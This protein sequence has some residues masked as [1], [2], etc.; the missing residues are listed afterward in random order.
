MT[1]PSPS[2]DRDTFLREAI[3]LARAG[4]RDGPGGPFGAVIVHEARIVGRG[5]NRVVG[6]MDPTAHAEVVAI[7]DACATLNTHV[8][9]GCDVYAT[10]EPCPM[11]LGA[12]YWARVDRVYYACDRDDARDAGFDDERISLE[13]ERPI[14]DRQLG[15]TQALRDEAITLFAEWGA[16]PH[17]MPY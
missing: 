1:P 3:E 4:M 8:L 9:K 17:R 2:P 6:S 10:C 15:M 12:L 16:N 14:A 5:T 7:R 11:C 13:L